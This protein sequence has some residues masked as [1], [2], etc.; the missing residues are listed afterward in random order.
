MIDGGSS[1]REP[2]DVFGRRFTSFR[3]VRFGRGALDGLD[4]G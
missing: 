4:A 2:D 3:H 1:G